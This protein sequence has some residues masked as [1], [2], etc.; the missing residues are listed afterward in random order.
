MHSTAKKT[1]N[2]KTNSDTNFSPSQ[3][4]SYI[5]VAAYYHAEK[6]GFNSDCDVDNWLAAEA[7]IDQMMA[8]GWR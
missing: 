6:K 8:R 1:G 3:R 5:A 2:R 7:E 4:R